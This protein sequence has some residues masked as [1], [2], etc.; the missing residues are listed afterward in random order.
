MGLF[1]NK[2]EHP[3]MFENE[4]GIRATNQAFHKIDY[5]SEFVEEQKKA[6]D[7]LQRE[8]DQLKDKHEQGE[9][10]IRNQLNELKANNQEQKQ[11][12]RDVMTLLRKFEGK[13]ETELIEQ[14]ESLK[15]TNQ[16]IVERLEKFE[17][18]NEQL[19][20]KMN[21]Y[22][23][24]QSKVVDQMS[25]QE[26]S[27]KEVINRMENQEA[28]TEKLIRQ[29]DHFRSIFFER[30]HYIVDKVENGFELTTAY[31][32][33]L[34]TGSDQPITLMIKKKQNSSE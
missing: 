29:M 26:E 9:V 7:L 11:F 5:F 31:I 33:K 34:M 21:E 28:L 27:Q 13:V 2:N 20:N 8:F 10:G 16:E 15:K 17:A 24:I 18:E 25:K 1:M 32:H 23:Q 30:T 4:D 6:N 22:L 19:T 12:E 14:L 3:D